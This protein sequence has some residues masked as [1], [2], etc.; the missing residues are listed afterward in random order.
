MIITCPACAKRYLVEET[1]I[2]ETGRHVQ[3]I[4]CQHEW[5]FK[6]ITEIPKHNQVQFDMIG[7]KSSVAKD[8]TRFSYTWVVMVTTLVV[9]IAG[10]YF[11]RHSLV[12]HFPKS[13]K[14]FQIIG[15]PIELKS[16][17]LT[18]ENIKP[19]FVSNDTNNELIVTGE[20]YN[21]SEQV[22]QVP[23][24]KITALGECAKAPLYE[25]VLAKVFKKNDGLCAVAKWTY[26]PSA[27]RLFPG[28]KLSFET[29]SEGP[30]PGA[31][32]VNIKF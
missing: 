23:I 9:M 3:C 6:P 1:A 24:L 26:T 8:G 5:F 25:K 18:L 22:Q 27:F 14:I 19:H 16:S 31:K 11:A 30:L 17:K 20:I 13:L 21:S 32:T 28:E 29:K 4:A 10:T 2:Q 15:I 12:L 7:V